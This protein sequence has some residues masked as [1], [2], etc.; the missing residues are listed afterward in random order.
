M[1]KKTN[2]LNALNEIN[3]SKKKKSIINQNKQVI[4]SLHNN[5]SKHEILKEEERGLLKKNR[6]V[7]LNNLRIF[8]YQNNNFDSIYNAINITE[9]YNSLSDYFDFLE[10]KLKNN[11]GSQREYSV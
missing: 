8:V 9:S 3:D 6:E 1:N 11:L 2:L 5:R 10:I 7:I 4:N